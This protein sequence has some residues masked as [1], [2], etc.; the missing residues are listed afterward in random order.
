MTVAASK[1]DRYMDAGVMFKQAGQEAEAE[2]CFSAAEKLIDEPDLKALARR[3]KRQADV[4]AGRRG[5]PLPSRKK[6][7]A[8][9][10]PNNPTPN[11]NAKAK[12]KA[13][14]ARP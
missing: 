3:A 10:K 7:A 1:F 9:S 2:M 5:E 4:D 12:E 8:A 6:I 14:G 13:A 11:A